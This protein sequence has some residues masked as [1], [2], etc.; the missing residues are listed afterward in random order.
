MRVQ[1]ALL[2]ADERA[3]S[4]LKAF[5]NLETGEV[6][7]AADARAFVAA[8]LAWPENEVVVRRL[9][10]E[11]RRGVCIVQATEARNLDAVDPEL[12][13]SVVAAGALLRRWLE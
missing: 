3:F 12:L 5:L 4:W 7:E 2:S 1:F 6:F 10:L 9:V 8:A 11:G 13:G